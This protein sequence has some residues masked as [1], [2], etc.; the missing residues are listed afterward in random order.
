MPTPPPVEACLAVIVHDGRVLVR[1]RRERGPLDGTWEFPGG[2]RRRGERGDVCARRETREETGLDARILGEVHRVRFDYPDRSVL[3]RF[4]HGVPR[5]GAAAVIPD[6]RW[7]DAAAL[8]RLPT[9][10]A[11]ASFAP[12]L[13]RLL[14]QS[15]RR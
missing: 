13:A 1:R 7:V 14:R 5:E 8:G 6:G 10:A 2:K 9:P 12:V 4:F 15:L 11:N 3:L